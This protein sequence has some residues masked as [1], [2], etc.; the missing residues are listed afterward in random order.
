MILK[1]SNALILDYFT[2]GK[3]KKQRTNNLDNLKS[4]TVSFSKPVSPALGE[5]N[6]QR[7]SFKREN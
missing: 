4:Q 7:V 2:V 3:R 6:L 1:S 5:A